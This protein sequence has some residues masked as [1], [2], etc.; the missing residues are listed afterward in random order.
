[1]NSFLG[2][3]R[4]DLVLMYVL[5]GVIFTFEMLG[6]YVPHMVTITQIVKAYVRM[7]LRFMI[8]AWLCWHFIVSD[9]VPQGSAVSIANR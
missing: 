3:Q 6:V 8:L 5:L 2:I 7:P 4:W 1:M 9:L